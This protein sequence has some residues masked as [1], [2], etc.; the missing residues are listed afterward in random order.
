MVDCMDRTGMS[1]PTSHRWPGAWVAYC[2]LIVTLISIPFSQGWCQQA[3]GA[4]QGIVLDVR[5]HQP[6]K[7]VLVRIEPG[8]ITTITKS[9]GT[10]L[11]SN[12]SPG[13]YELQFL[14]DGYLTAIFMHQA[15]DAGMMRTLRV[16]LVPSEGMAGDVIQIGGIEILADKHLLPD[17]LA[18]STI[19][20][21]NELEHL[22]ATSLGDALDLV[23]GVELRNQPH[24]KAP[25]IAQFRDPR[26]AD[27]MS[28]LG[29]KIMIDG[30]PYTN[31]ANLQ[32]PLLSGV[33]TGTGNGVDL[34][35]IPADPLEAIEVIRGV[36]PAEHGDLLAGLVKVT[37]RASAKAGH[38]LK[39]KNN[40]DTKEINWGGRFRLGRTSM[41][42][43]LNWA[44][45][46]R[47]LRKD[48][49]HTQRL[50]AQ[51][52]L[53]RHDAENK[54]LSQ[55]QFGYVKLI[56][57][58]R[59]NP[60]DPDAMA[61]ADR[62]F[63][64]TYDYQT[65][66][67][68]A[69]SLS[70]HSNLFINYRRHNSYK[71]YRIVADNRVVSPLMIPGTTIGFKPSPSYL[72]KC[73]ILGDELSIGHDVQCRYESFVGRLFQIIKLGHQIQFDDNFGKGRQFDPLYP[74][75]LGNRPRRFDAIPGL[76]QHAVYITDQITGRWGKE[77]TLDI[78]FRLER[79][80]SDRWPHLQ[81]LS[82]KHGLF[83]NPRLNLAYFL[84]T[85]SQVRFGYGQF[86]KAPALIYCYPDPTYLDVSDLLTKFIAT[87]TILIRDSLITTYI[88]DGAN[89]K[90]KG[91][92]ER[93][94]ELS[95]DQQ[96]GPIGFS[97]TGFY[98]QRNGEPHL[99]QI[100]I[101]YHKYLR[102][103]ASDA[104][105]QGIADTLMSHYLT[106]I[107]AGWAKFDGVELIVKS[108]RL[109]QFPF[110]GSIMISY[111]HVKNGSKAPS[112][113]VPFPDFTVPKY[114]PAASWTQKLLV[115]YQLNY[116]S[117]ALGIWLSLL[118]QHVPHY[119]T[120]HCGYGDSLAVAYYDGLTNKTILIPQAARDDPAYLR[121][122]LNKN[123]RDYRV[124]RY[125][126]KWLINVRV[127]KSLFRGAE[128]SLY[129]NNVLNDRAFYEDPY[130][131]GFYYP[132]NPEI[133]YGIEFSMV[134]DHWMSWRSQ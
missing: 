7:Q 20:R 78:G 56:E 85:N 57:A 124:Y 3:T 47:D 12:L 29:T 43:N 110:D 28:G 44:Y 116:I 68:I 5:T 14:K 98:S 115:T 39:A 16:E 55:H 38:R 129:V 65:S 88:F 22:Q 54:P 61:S 75:H 8:S 51:F 35:E 10:F 130:H 32:G 119:Q 112:W 42:Y 24:L 120:R 73:S 9:N 102:L 64:F 89:P 83:F 134:I 46:Q 122:R 95:W 31:N 45:S 53:V 41:N 66:F 60:K 74:D 63:R 40:P 2:F 6:I 108:R 15:I 27:L 132:G 67:P 87:D 37:T 11:L 107:N 26:P 52:K 71:Q 4:V 36:A 99:E 17:K 86:S 104:T 125:P 23:P 101:V 13:T 90:L 111:Q 117:R 96:V 131:P 48:Y 59:Q 118:A 34:R 21:S 91:L 127:S 30:I 106:N 79:Y 109:P 81:F 93:K 114:Q 80:T 100:P 103:R 70:I 1:P 84:T 92:R 126:D 58:V 69:S 128:L 94:F 76:L 25:R 33:F 105:G 113:G 72:F 123:P 18:T 82:S 133:F 62:G 50:A 49:D 121:Y 77:F 19:I 97:L